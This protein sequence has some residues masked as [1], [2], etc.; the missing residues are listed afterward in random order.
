MLSE[1]LSS[2]NTIRHHEILS[3]SNDRFVNSLSRDASFYP[4][5]LV[6][7]VRTPFY[8]RVVRVFCVFRGHDES[9]TTDYTEKHG[10]RI[11]IP[12]ARRNTE[13]TRNDL[14]LGFIALPRIGTT[15]ENYWHSPDSDLLF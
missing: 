14:T 3:Q 9:A 2:I 1:I 4:H 6:S 8:F 11:V 5:P 15:R 10:R 12:N 13:K 7:V